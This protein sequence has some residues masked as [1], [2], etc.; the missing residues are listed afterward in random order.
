MTIN[1]LKTLFQNIATAH[2][3]INDFAYGELWEIEEKMNKEA[4]YPML[5]VSPIQSTTQEQ[6]KERSFHFMIF[7]MISKDKEDVVEVWSD[8]E[9]ILDDIIKIFKNESE[10]YELVGDPTLLPF[11]EDNAD[12]AT[13][14]RTELTIRTDFNSNYCDIPSNTFVS[15]SNPAFAYIL[16]QDGNVVQTLYKGETYSV[17]IASGIDEGGATQTYSIQV[18]DI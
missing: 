2:K 11:K 4:K 17:I 13:G 6:V 15:P 10:N 18:V 7:D 5:Y 1:Q 14:Y 3:Q 16:D 8:T 12:W 9:Q